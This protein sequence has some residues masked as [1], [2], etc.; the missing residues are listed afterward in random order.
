MRDITLIRIVLS[1]SIAWY[2]LRI[3]ALF[4]VYLHSMNDDID[5][6]ERQQDPEKNVRR[7]KEIPFQ[8][9]GSTRFSMN[10]MYVKQVYLRKIVFLLNKD[11]HKEYV[12]VH[13]CSCFYLSNNLWSTSTV[14]ISSFEFN[15]FLDVSSQLQ[16]VS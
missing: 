7:G 2:I 14:T 5:P 15:G 10:V 13:V 8:F 3:I 11:C 1:N 6:I 12:C 9:T 16:Q 4:I